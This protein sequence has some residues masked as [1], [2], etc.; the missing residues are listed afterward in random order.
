M[1]QETSKSE[2]ALP[3]FEGE[4]SAPPR[5][6]WL[7]ALLAITGLLLIIELSRLVARYVLVFRRPTEVRLTAGGVELRG[8]TLMVGK[9]LREQVTVLPREGLVRV[10]REVRYPRLAMYAGLIA[11]ALGSYVGVSLVV[12]GLRAASPSMLGTGLLVA[13]LGLGLDFVLSS[14]VPGLV[15]KSRVVFVPRRGAVICVT[16]VAPA[17]ADALL[18]ELAKAPRPTSGRSG[19]S[20]EAGRADRGADEAERKSAGDSR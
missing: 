18:A 4:T 5:G 13:L 9:L 2:Q 1:A 17:R 16:A 12:D 6:P 7:T 3:N 15:G 8:R 10:T 19:P 20:V 14:L 11:L